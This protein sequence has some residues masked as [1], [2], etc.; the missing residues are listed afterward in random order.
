MAAGRTRS[1]EGTASR[2]GNVCRLAAEGTVPR[3]TAD[4]AAIMV[5]IRLCSPLRLS[6]AQVPAAAPAGRLGAAP[7]AGSACW[8]HALY[9]KAI[10]GAKAKNDHLP[11]P[12]GSRRR[13]RVQVHLLL[14]HRL[15]RPAVAWRAT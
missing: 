5:S 14:D 3:S 2:T 7:V 15:L 4:T 10:H 1:S 13:R 8:A 9:M 6:L 11:L 12:R